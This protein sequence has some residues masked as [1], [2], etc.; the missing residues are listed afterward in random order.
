[1]NELTGEI[2]NDAD[3]GPGAD[4]DSLSAE[5]VAANEKLRKTSEVDAKREPTTPKPAR[6][7]ALRKPLPE[8]LERIANPIPVAP[9]QRPCPQCGKDRVCIGH[10]ITEI[11]ELRPP[12]VIVRSDAREKLK[13]EA[14]EGA[15]V[16]APVGDNVVAAGRL[17]PRLVA[18]LV[19][20]KWAA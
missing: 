7:P 8:N 19:V 16:R 1:M 9:E 15:I 11:A 2:A 12:T 13:C 14:C 17:G 3:D 6:Q 20:D 4:D 18:E 5:M 10:D